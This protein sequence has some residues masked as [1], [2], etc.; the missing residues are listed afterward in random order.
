MRDF[1]AS[2]PTQAKS[3]KG[4][5]GQTAAELDALFLSVLGR[6]FKGEL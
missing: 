1:G 2:S 4:S 5:Q 3:V 6:A